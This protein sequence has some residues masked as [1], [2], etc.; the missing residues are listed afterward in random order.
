MR[1]ISTKIFVEMIFILLVAFSALQLAKPNN[2]TEMAETETM[3]QTSNYCIE[4]S[5]CAFVK[6][7]CPF[8]CNALVNKER[9]DEI[10]AKIEAFESNCVKKCT[11]V[12]K[13]KCSSGFCTAA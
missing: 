9:L 4:D 1:L 12:T 5:D 3:I 2:I 8:T 10:N 6:N 13:A 11:S 7:K